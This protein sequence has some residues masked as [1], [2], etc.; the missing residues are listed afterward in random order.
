MNGSVPMSTRLTREN[1]HG[2]WAAIATPFDD[3]NRL[4]VDVLRENIRR[5]HAGGVHGIYTT[6]A[7]GEF[8]AIEIDEFRELVTVFS[9][10]CQRLGIPTQVGCTWSSTAGVVDRLQVCAELGV[11]GAHVGHPYF[12]PMTRESLHAFWRDLAAAVPDWFALIHYNTPR[13]PNVL[14]GPDYALLAAGIP[15]LVGVKFVGSDLSEFLNLVA[16]APELSCFVGE[17]LLTPLFP[18]GVRGVYSWFAN[19]NAPYLCEWYR[20]LEEGQWDDAVRR[21]RRLHEFGLAFSDLRAEGHLHAVLNKARAAAS[22]YLVPSNRTRA[23]YLP[24]SNERV[25]E[26]RETIVRDFPDLMGSE[27]STGSMAPSHAGGLAP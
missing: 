1:L 14:T 7:D 22:D 19:M 13:C 15:N 20:E 2:V 3:S 6:D 27:T 8:Y 9:E 21:Q 17:Q 23:P 18:F 10:E 16:H 26:L 25:A 5:L 11:L 4:D 12:M 24:I